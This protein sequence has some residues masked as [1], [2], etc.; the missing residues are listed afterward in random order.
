MFGLWLQLFFKMRNFSHIFLETIVDIVKLVD[1]VDSL[2]NLETKVNDFD[3]GKLN[4][5][6]EDSKT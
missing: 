4:P 2:N 5:V 1:V 6:A 3:V